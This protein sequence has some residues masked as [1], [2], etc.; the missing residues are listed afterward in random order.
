MVRSMAVVLI[1]VAFVAGL[2]GLLRP[3]SEAVRDVEWAPALESAREAASYDLVGPQSVPEGWTAT[4]V[5]YEAGAST[6]D[7]VWRMSFVTDEGAYL[8][9]V[10]RAGDAEAI[11]RRELP[12]FE[13]D[14][15]WRQGGQEWTRLVEAG[16]RD[17]DVALVVERDDSVVILIGSGDYSD[18][19][20]FS[21]S[22]R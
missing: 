10:Q 3:S 2:V 16:A 19:E 9:L 4:R 22:L 7:R 8:G 21:A 1:P 18:L 11:V 6:E 17:P 12:D 13:V 20:A 5:A 15:V 14:G